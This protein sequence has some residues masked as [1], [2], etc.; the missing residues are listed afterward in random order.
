[1]SL[2]TVSRG[3][4]VCALASACAACAIVDPYVY[5]KKKEYPDAVLLARMPTQQFA[6]HIGPAISY[7]DQWRFTYVR[8]ASQHATM[9]NVSAVALIPLSATALFYGTTGHG[10]GDRI[11]RLALGGASIYGA[12]QFLTSNPRQEL[13]LQGAHALTCAIAASR[14][15]IVTNTWLDSLH[16]ESNRLIDDLSELERAQVN[17]QSQISASALAPTNKTLIAAKDAEIKAAKAIADARALLAKSEVAQMEIGRSGQ[18]LMNTVRSIT[19]FVD[20][21]IASTQPDLQTLRTLVTGL[22][23]V[24]AGFAGSAWPT[25]G[26]SAG[27]TP[28]PAG[29]DVSPEMAQFMKTFHNA[30]RI[31]DRP[32]SLDQARNQVALAQ[33][34]VARSSIPI[35]VKIESI[36][37]VGT[38]ADVVANCT[39]KDAALPFTV[40]PSSDTQTVAKGKFVTLEA[41]GGAGIPRYQVL[42]ANADAVAVTVSTQDLGQLVVIVTGK[43]EVEASVAPTLVFSDGHGKRRVAVKLVVTK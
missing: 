9:R 4:I 2:N 43:D 18:T 28:A 3:V 15:F 13:Y 11:T 34:M 32:G 23:D 14:P 19:D 24:A 12:N 6:G 26:D 20:S 30:F 8:A 10:S 35:V 21:Q 36:A 29:D 25:P 33:S 16:Q 38:Q 5:P 31:Q 39:P 42:G 41:R 27:T 22:G 40:T 37:N 7:A 1:M 17:L